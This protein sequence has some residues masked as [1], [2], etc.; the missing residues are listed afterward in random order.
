MGWAYLASLGVLG[1]VILMRDYIVVEL[2]EECVGKFFY[3]AF[4]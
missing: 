2:V 4:F 3:G 1:G